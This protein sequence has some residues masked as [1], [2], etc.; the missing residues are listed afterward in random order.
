ML[1]FLKAYFERLL[2]SERSYQK[3]AASF[4]VGTFIALTPTIPFQT[5]L[6][7]LV[8]WLC[9]LNATVTF[10]AV[11]LVNNPFTMIPIYVV[12]YA[13][14]IWFFEGLLGWSLVSYNPAWVA[15]LNEFLSRYIDIKKYLGSDFCL[16]YLLF[17][18][19]LFALMVCIP[20]YP[21]LKLV[22]KRLIAQIEKAKK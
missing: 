18:G 2:L 13:V 12:G 7:F 20:L 17:G 3:L 10:A 4:T 21:I 14:G 9:R 8:S 11:Y 6:L 16:W 1:R 5:P 15:K 22:F 19:F